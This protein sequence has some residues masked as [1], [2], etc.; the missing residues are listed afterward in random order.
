MKKYTADNS[1]TISLWDKKIEDLRNS[2][3]NEIIRTLA[4]SDSIPFIISTKFFNI[5]EYGINIANYTKY[6]DI[7]NRSLKRSFETFLFR[8][9]SMIEQ[10]GQ[11]VS[12]EE[13]LVEIKIE[14]WLI[15]NQDQF[16]AEL[17][18]YINN[19]YT[20]ISQNNNQNRSKNV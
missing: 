10:M 19:I 17:F 14:S 11:W 5:L 13:L 18:S 6:I 2:K 16:N 15:I 7:K 12:L 1:Y 9:K 20:N 3:K 4:Q 8:S